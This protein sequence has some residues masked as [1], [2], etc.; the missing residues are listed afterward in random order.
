MPGFRW[1]AIA[2]FRW[3]T[4]A[5]LQRNTVACFLCSVA[6]GRRMNPLPTR[7]SA[8]QKEAAA[9]LRC[10][11]GFRDRRSPL[12]LLHMGFQIPGQLVEV[13]AHADQTCL[14]PQGLHVHQLLEGFI[15]QFKRPG[16]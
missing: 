15:H 11:G 12:A 14:G 8:A 2:G 9:S 10:R 13:G 4:V 7:D 5:D 3:D 1:N 6:S 16:D